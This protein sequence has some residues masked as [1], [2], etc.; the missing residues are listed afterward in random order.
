MV[1]DI[2]QMAAAHKVKEEMEKPKRTMKTVTGTCYFCKQMVTVN[3]PEEWRD[4]AKYD[5]LATMECNCK[6]GGEYRHM[7]AEK[8]ACVTAIKAYTEPLKESGAGE[9][10]ISAIS[11]IQSGAAKSI[12]VK[13]GQATYNMTKK[14][15]KIE[16]SRKEVI[17]NSVY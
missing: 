10:L 14:D 9:I 11:Q 3:A 2:G 16:L 8:A 1:N 12:Q 17:E 13:T 5:E 15:G 6:E 4:Q 7:E